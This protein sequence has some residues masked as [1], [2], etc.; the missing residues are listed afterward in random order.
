MIASV[1]TGIRR[2]RNRRH[3]NRRRGIVAATLGCVAVLTVAGCSSDTSSSGS[4]TAASSS[5]AGPTPAVADVITPVTA[6]AIDD[7]MAV[8]G[9]DGKTHLAYELLLINVTPD[10]VGVR[11][12]EVSASGQSLLTLE[13]AA[14][15]ALTRR[16]S[17]APG[18]D[19]AGG[20]YARLTLDVVLPDGAPTPASLSNTLTVAPS[21]PQPPLIPA[22]IAEPITVTVD[23]QEAVVVDT[24]LYGD[25]W[26]NGDGCCGT[27]AHRM[28][29]NPINGRFWLAERFAIDWV[30]LDEAGKLYV[31][32]P[33]K[34]SSY[35]YY[36][37]DIHS[38]ADSTVVGV[39]DG[40][41]DQIPGKSPTGLPL[42]QYGGNHVVAKV[43]DGVYV[44]Y[45]HLEPGSVKVEVGDT[46]TPGQVIGRLGNSGNSDAPHLHFHAMNGPDPLRASGI[47]Y[48]YKQFTVAHRLQSEAQ[49]E[50]LLT[51]GGPPEYAS[52]PVGKQV[53][54]AMPMDLDV[55]DFPSK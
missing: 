25:G 8:V 53:T 7:P 41:P 30:Q 40:L 43:A 51:T 31:G 54:D 37:A 15:T 29:A 42:D 35:P 16:G 3:R 5:V 34:L 36:G 11:S 44:F 33:T 19:L 1:A 39:V 49:L 2:H 4:S 10:P 17:G 14:L 18:L 55:V 26:L 46:L 52:E 45:A 9:S 20:E 12:L 50:P 13:G 28:A 32:D 47:P 38:V 24:P 21:K 27:S 6:T 48:E 22:V 23:Q